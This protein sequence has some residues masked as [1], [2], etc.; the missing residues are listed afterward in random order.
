MAEEAVRLPDP[1]AE[2]TGG[3][4]SA[5]GGVSMELIAKSS[6]TYSPFDGVLYAESSKA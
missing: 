6:T 4:V 5:G 3:V 2:I 1:T